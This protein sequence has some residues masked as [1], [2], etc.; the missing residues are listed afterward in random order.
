ML[1][2]VKTHDLST[3][4]S[5]IL[6]F[7]NQGYRNA[8]EIARI[9]NIPV[10]TVRY[11]VKKIREKGN[12]RHKCGNGRRCKLTG[13]DNI[14]IGQLVLKNPEI[15]SKEIAQTLRIKNGQDISRWTVQRQLHR[16]GYRHVLPR[17]TQMLTDEHKEARVEW[18]KR[19]KNDN[20][21]RTVFSDET[22]FQLFRNSIR[23][24]SK[25]VK[26]E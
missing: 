22:C 18:A 15:T 24:W 5:V 21:N 12:V 23:R 8:A 17:A 6:H 13:K 16:L 20:W 11:N 7:F 2:K 26:Q 10:Q 19:H 25:N 3:N 1:R 4:R 9:T 14:L